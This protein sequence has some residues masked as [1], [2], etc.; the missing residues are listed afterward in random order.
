MTFVVFLA[1]VCLISSTI[2]LFHWRFR[3]GKRLYYFP[4]HGQMR[5]LFN[6]LVAAIPLVAILFLGGMV[7]EMPFLI[8]SFVYVILSDV[9]SACFRSMNRG[10]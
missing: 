7:N 4:T 10:N 9:Y 5:L 1:I 8:V 3:A 2:N 6:A